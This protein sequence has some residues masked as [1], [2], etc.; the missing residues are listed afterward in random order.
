[1]E[2]SAIVEKLGSYKT[3]EGWRACADLCS[4]IVFWLAAI[5]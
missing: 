4:A 5:G 1:M 2:H 3:V